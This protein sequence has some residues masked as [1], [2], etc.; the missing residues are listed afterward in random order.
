MGTTARTQSTKSP[1]MPVNS[2]AIE[3]SLAL[4]ESGEV[5]TRE[6]AILLIE[7]ARTGALLEA[8]SSLRNRVKGRTISYSRKA[9]LPLTT[10]CRD[11]CGYCTF[12]RDPGEPGGRYMMPEDVVAA[13]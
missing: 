7:R 5:L 3:R 13:A 8:A 2:L 1:V 9:F 6:D 11:R 12:R 10:Y 4:G